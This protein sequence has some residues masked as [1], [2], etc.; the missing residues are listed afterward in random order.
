MSE[1][2]TATWAAELERLA[3]GLGR[4]GPDEICCEGLSSRQCSILRTLAEQEGARISGLASSAGITPSAMTRVLEKLEA[5]DLVKRV[6]GN[7]NDGRA[8]KVAI[9][10]RGR[11]VRASIDRLIKTRTE[12]IL[13]ALPDGLRPQLLTLAGGAGSRRSSAWR[14]WVPAAALLGWAWRT[15]GL[16]LRVRMQRDSGAPMGKSAK[17]QSNRYRWKPVPS[18]W[19]SATVSSI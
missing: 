3:R 14:K 11:E 5:R 12:T 6:R 2:P 7:G 18:T 17:V 16:D 10:V 8:A 19:L 1:N 9:T 15:T 4:V 13:S